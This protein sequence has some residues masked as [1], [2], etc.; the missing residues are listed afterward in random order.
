MG[1]KNKPAIDNFKNPFP[2]GR[3]QGVGHMAYDLI[4][5]VV[6]KPNRKHKGFLD[7][8]INLHKSF[9]V[10]LPFPLPVI[11]ILISFQYNNMN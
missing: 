7:Y 6:S 10:L 4:F 11:T 8:V 3:G 2:L 1:G 9:T 5:V